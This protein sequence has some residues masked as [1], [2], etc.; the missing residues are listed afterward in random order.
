MCC[1]GYFVLLGVAYIS[2]L[3]VRR[4]LVW[5][6]ESAVVRLKP[7][8]VVCWHSC[9]EKFRAGAAG[10][11]GDD[12]VAVGAAGEILLE[13]VEA[14]DCVHG[15]D[16]ESG[17][18]ADEL[19]HPARGIVFETANPLQDAGID[20]LAMIRAKGFTGYTRICPE[21]GRVIVCVNL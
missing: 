20:H 14:G 12:E 7:A 2:A 5:I 15:V 19:A 3:G 13:M 1:V 18:G 17:G 16:E 8:I 9:T 4:A 11:G 10:N 21:T 6:L